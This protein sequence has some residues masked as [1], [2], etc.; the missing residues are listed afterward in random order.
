MVR[1]SRTPQ[2][3]SQ[4]TVIMSVVGLGTGVKKRK[5]FKFHSPGQQQRK[6][7]ANPNLVT[8]RVDTCISQCETK[9]TNGPHVTLTEGY[10]CMYLGLVVGS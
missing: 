2:H 8:Y 5:P 7:C 4:G 6:V 3:E 9:H 1:H 10:I